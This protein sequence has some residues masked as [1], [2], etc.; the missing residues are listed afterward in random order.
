MTELAIMKRRVF[1][2]AM[3]SMT[4]M[5]LPAAAQVAPPPATA[6]ASTKTLAEVDP[7]RL[8]AARPVINRIWPLGTYARVM[9]GMMDQVMQSTLGSM[10]DMRMDDVAA[11]TGTDS[12]ATAALKGKTMG[13]ALLA[14]DPAYK[15]RMKITMD[16]MMGEM[17][18]IMT[19]VEPDVREAL[20]HAYARRFTVEQLQDLDRFFATPTGS[21]YA[22]ESMT[23]MMGPD[24]AKVMQSFVPHMMKEMPTIMAKLAEATK[25]LPPL[26]KKA[27]RQ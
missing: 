5:A 14:E 8:A 24:M 15:E 9:H 1:W 21:A 2:P 16:V 19:D 4:A 10:Y 27:P 23:I 25:G 12:K 11:M 13:E 22:S 17:T 20:A 18:R 26:P 6:A 3:L 7:A